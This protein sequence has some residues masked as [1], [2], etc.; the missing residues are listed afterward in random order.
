[1]LRQVVA[2]ISVILLAVIGLC[3]CK[4][5]NTAPKVPYIPPDYYNCTETTTTDLLNAYYSH[6][7]AVSDAENVLNGH[8]FVFKNIVVQAS[9]LK[10]ATDTYI[11]VNLIQCYFLTPGSAAELKEG[12]VVDVVGI[13]AGVCK[14]YLGT[15]VFTGCIFLPAGSVQL[16]SP[17]GGG[18]NIPG[19]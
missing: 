19:Y 5:F 8:V 11:W 3:G 13:D 16:P 15:L 6:Y 1:M 7:S 9:A 4:S 10:Y 18:V 12:D 2:V 17:G 14:E